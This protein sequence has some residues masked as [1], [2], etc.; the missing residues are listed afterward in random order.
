MGLN[1]LVGLFLMAALVALGVHQGSD[2]NVTPLEVFQTFVF[3]P[4][5]IIAVLVTDRLTR[6]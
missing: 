1:I 2:D 3:I 5:S 4:L 6:R